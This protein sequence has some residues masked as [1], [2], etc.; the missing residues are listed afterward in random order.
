M[1]DLDLDPALPFTINTENVTLCLVGCGGTG[2][3]IA[4]TIARMASHI[5]QNR[6]M[7]LRVLF[8]DGDT[9]EQKNVGRQ[10]FCD[11][12]VG[13]NKAQTLTTRFNRAFGLEIE[14]LPAMCDNST[15]FNLRRG[16]SSLIMVGAV[17]NHEARRCLHSF[18]KYPQV[19]WLDSGNHDASGQVVFGSAAEVRHMKGSWAVPGIAGH[20]PCASLI[21]PEL[22]EAPAEVVIDCAAAMQQNF[23]TLMVNQMMA[24]IVG[25]YLYDLLIRKELTQFKTVVDLTTLSMRSTPITVKNIAEAVRQKPTYL[26]HVAKPRKAKA[27]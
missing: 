1:L 9:V 14:A 13:M 5:K 7:N 2:S 22:L 11:A 24:A 27:S 3:H 12:E 6:L 19:F 25:Q 10:L 20:L 15:I 16:N 23:Q 8:M 18:A 4:Q 26:T 17:D 21:Y